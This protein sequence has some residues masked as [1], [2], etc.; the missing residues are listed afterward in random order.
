MSVFSLTL[1]YGKD[2]AGPIG[3][4]LEDST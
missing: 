1:T 4:F 2:A 3:R